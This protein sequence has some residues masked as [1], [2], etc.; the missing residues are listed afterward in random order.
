MINA[1]TRSILKL[2]DD[3]SDPIDGLQHTKDGNKDQ[4]CIQQKIAD[5]CLTTAKAKSMPKEAWATCIMYRALERNTG[6]VG[7]PSGWCGEKPKN[8]Q[9]M[10]IAQ[11]QDPASDGAG[12]HNAKVETAVARELVTLGFQPE[13][14]VNLAMRTGTFKAGDKGDN[15]GRGNSCNSIP[16]FKDFGKPVAVPDVYATED[17]TK[18]GKPVS[19]VVFGRKISPGQLIDCTILAE[20]TN[21]P[22]GRIV[23]AI[24]KDDL[25]T[26]LKALAP[27][28]APA[29]PAAEK[30]ATPAPAPVAA[31]PETPPAPV[32]AKPET[33]AADVAAKPETP[34][35]PAPVAAKPDTPAAPV[36]AKPETPAAPAPAPVAAKPETP[37]AP[38]ADTPAA[39]ASAK[40]AEIADAAVALASAI[41]LERRRR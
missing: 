13:M 1:D 39:P 5:T 26:E 11:H 24:K 23:P 21:S 38:A 27:P 2:S 36:A 28:A 12:D 14:A 34:A 7:E 32:A 3:K 33:P 16:S 15:S 10:N 31:K 20:L 22:T 40:P 19:G 35:A 4:D 6:R 29:A 18:E 17:G 25:L 30:P 8:I 9:L 41:T 37:A